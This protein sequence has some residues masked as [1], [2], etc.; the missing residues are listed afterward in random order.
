MSALTDEERHVLSLLAAGRTTR[1]VA[2]ALGV[3]NNA[4]SMRLLR[5]RQRRRA[6]TTVQL[7]ADAVRE[8]LL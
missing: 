5:L 7:V 6:E 3:A 2:R 1:Q 8:G 4:L